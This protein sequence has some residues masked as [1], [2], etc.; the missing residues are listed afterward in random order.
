MEAISSSTPGTVGLA[1]LTGAKAPPEARQPEKACRRPVE[2]AMD[3]YIPERP[4]EPSGRYWLG[5][6]EEGRPRVCFDDPERAADAPGAPE[7]G[8]GPEKKAA[9]KGEGTCT[10]DTSKVDREI[11][12]LKQRRAELRQRLNAETDEAAVRKLERK[13]AQVEGELRQKDNDAYR[14]QH[15]Q[16][17]YA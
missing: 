17:S 10:G 11:R 6:D 13:L 5:R 9:G 1:A 15:T 4:R 12:R 14:R 7:Q 16:F 8:R 2:P 3:E